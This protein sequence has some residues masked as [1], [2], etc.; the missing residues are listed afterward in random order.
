MGM[1]NL[2]NSLKIEDSALSF[3]QLIDN[4]PAEIASAL[5]QKEVIILPSRERENT[6]YGSTLDT[7]DYLNE[8]KINVDIYSTDEEYQELLLHGDNVWLGTFFITNLVIP[9]FCGVIS[10]YVYD[11]IKAKNDDRISL[12]FLV[13]R[14]DG[15]TTS[16]QFDGKVEGLDKA[17]GAVKKFSNDD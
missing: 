16:V 7:L 2:E 15:N 12:K 11:K 4:A 6:Y 8:N 10:A 1:M 13:E 14:K 3:K 5:E 9:V 17:L